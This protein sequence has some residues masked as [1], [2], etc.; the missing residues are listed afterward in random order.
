MEIFYSIFLIFSMLFAIFSTVLLITSVS[1]PKYYWCSLTYM[2]IFFNHYYKAYKETLAQPGDLRL[3]H[4]NDADFPNIEKGEIF[5]MYDDEKK[6]NSFFKRNSGGEIHPH[7]I[8]ADIFMP[9]FT[10]LCLV[11]HVP[12]NL[13]PKGI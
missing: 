8:N 9:V 4:L 13:I 12:E 1:A 11:K 5:Y 7:L 10:H 6:V 2:Y 3:V